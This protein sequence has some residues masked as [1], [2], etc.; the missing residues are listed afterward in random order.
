MPLGRLYC[1]DMADGREIEVKFEVSGLESL[2]ERLA[3]QG[4]HPITPRTHEMNV[5]YD[6]PGSPLR[7][8][9]ALL[10]VR[11]YGLKSTLTYK[12]RSKVGPRR[13]KS[14]REIETSVEDGRL[15]AEILEAAGFKN[16]IVR[17]Y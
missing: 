6:L 12:D 9:G 15:L 11:R 2:A 17:K 1:P 4:F 5:L 13:H 3:T 16:P 8:R 7:R 14:R 10:R